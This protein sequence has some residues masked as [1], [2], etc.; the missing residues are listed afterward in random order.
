MTEVRRDDGAAA[1]VWP[2]GGYGRVPF[3]VFCAQGIFDREDELL[4]RGNHWSY[5]GLAAE[6]PEPGDFY[7]GLCRSNALYSHSR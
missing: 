6:V 4:F 3:D 1:F 7:Y 2:E 5:L